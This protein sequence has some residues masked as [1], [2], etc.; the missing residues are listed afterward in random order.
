MEI[1]S[2]QDYWTTILNDLTQFGQI[3][4]ED[5]KFNEIANHV[6]RVLQNTLILTEDEKQIKHWEDIVNVSGEGLTQFQRKV[7]L[8]FLLSEKSYIPMNLLKKALNKLLGEG[9]YILNV[10]DENN[11]IYLGFS[12]YPI[13][14]KVDFLLSKTIPSYYENEV[15]AD[16]LPKDYLPAD[17]LETT[18]TQT[19][20]V[21]TPVDNDFGLYF[22]VT[23]TNET[24]ANNFAISMQTNE[25]GYKNIRIGSGTNASLTWWT[26]GSVKVPGGVSVFNKRV[27][28][29]GNYK[30]SR[31]LTTDSEFGHAETVMKD[32]DVVS[33]CFGFGRGI[34]V[35]GGLFSHWLN[36]ASY[37][38]AYGI[39]LSR[40][41]AV[42][43]DLSPALDPSGTPCM[44]DKM[45]NQTI[46]NDGSGQ[47]V[48]GL[49]MHQ[50][51]NLDKLP[52]SGG[53]LTV[54]L[55]REAQL[56]QHNAEV[57]TALETARLNGWLIGVQY[58]E[59]D[60]ESEIYNKYATCTTTEEVKAVNKDY[61][62]DLT[63][64][65][66]WIYPLEKLNSG[67][68]LLRNSTI[69]GFS[70]T[71]LP[72][73]E[74]AIQMFSE[75]ILDSFNV[76]MPK[77]L[78]M[79]GM[80]TVGKLNSFSGNIDKVTEAGGTFNGTGLKHFSSGLPSLRTSGNMFAGCELDKPS[81]LLI[82]ETIK[83]HSA[84][85]TIGIDASLQNDEEVLEAIALIQE[86]RGSVTVQWNGT[87]PVSTYGL[88]GMP[89]YAAMI[90]GVNGKEFEWGHYVTNW[91][92]NGYREFT[93]VE[94]AKEYFGIEKETA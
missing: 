54:S 10:D 4:T 8:L 41:K 34:Y 16:K 27:L 29:K 56:V 57:E 14:G 25:G 35:A 69:K 7:N 15:E 80:F 21:D 17:F 70:V 58:H 63:V 37:F 49:T 64:D 6:W 42:T 20:M 61:K 72:N 55:S 67:N 11:K 81:V 87:S 30:N 74:E 23:A 83:T 47:F 76:D 19:L 43:H 9:E 73:L 82:A 32:I 46:Y 33:D 28:W 62:T 78:N 39:K 31:L 18:G 88:R 3:S 71:E 94:E 22:D 90:D 65:G 26:G 36:M 89:V 79:N 75:V 52:N 59:P 68:G 93:T 12:N 24:A 45:T 53:E 51:I 92:E 5:V 85:L 86:K 2:K 48:I 13:K 60:A 77:L 44:Y 38:K 91:E 40:G 66:E 1:V 50:A 84:G